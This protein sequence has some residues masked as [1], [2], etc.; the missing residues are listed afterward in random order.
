[1][2]LIRDYISEH[3]HVLNL[4]GEAVRAI[5]RGDLPTARDRLAAMAEELR[6]HFRGEETGLFAV[7]M[8]TDDLFAQHIEPLVREHR[9]L[10][11]LLATVDIAGAEGQQAIRDAVEH[12]FE[13]T[14]K[15]EDGLFPAALTSLDG[16]QWDAAIQAWHDAHPGREMVR[17]A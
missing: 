13:H 8:S 10:E 16:D 1:M 5:N 7:M 9:E 6:S 11:A 4:G 12:L 2:P 14:R 15:E 3:A 17:W